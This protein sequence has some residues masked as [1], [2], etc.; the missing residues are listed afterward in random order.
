MDHL[1]ETINDIL[2]VLNQIAFLRSSNFIYA[3]ALKQ[4][5]Q[6]T[7]LMH[8]LPEEQ[9]TIYYSTLNQRLENPPVQGNLP[10]RYRYSGK[11]FR[12]RKRLQKKA[13]AALGYDT[14]GL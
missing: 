8:S 9:Y 7:S 5:R 1:Q 10:I 13:L 6:L 3:P 14:T 4:F 12:A 11:S 2:A